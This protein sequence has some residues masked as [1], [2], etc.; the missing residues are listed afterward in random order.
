[1]LPEI[2]HPAGKTGGDLC[3]GWLAL[4][5]GMDFA[6][7]T[8]ISA[9]ALGVRSIADGFAL[10][11][12][13]GNARLIYAEDQVNRVLSYSLGSV[14]APGSGY[15]S[16]PGLAAP[17]EI[18][19]LDPGASLAFHIRGSQ[20]RSYA[21]DS[22]IGTMTSAVL[23]PTGTPGA[24]TWVPTP[25]VGIKGVQTFTVIGGATGGHAAIS[26]YGAAGLKLF[27]V[28]ANGSLNLT[29]QISDSDK[30]HI[31]N[32]SATA[33]LTLGGQAYLLTLSSLENGITSFA[34]DGAGKAELVDSLG[35]RDQLPISGPEA[36]RIVNLAGQSFAVIASTG[37]SSLTVVR[38]ND[39]GCL[40]QT[41]HVIDDAST[42]FH[43]ASV[44]DTFTLNGRSFL[45]TAGADAGI[46]VMELLPGG[47]LA[48][49]AT[50]VF[51]TGAGFFAAKGLDVV[52]NGTT[53]WIF[54]L[55][56]RS[57]RLQRFDLDLSDL[58][59]RYT[60]QNGLAIGSSKDDLIMGSAGNDSLS[61]GGGDDRIVSGGGADT[62]TGG[63]GAD[64]FVFGAASDDLVITDFVLHQDRIDLSDWGRVYSV[65]ALSITPT[66]DG[67][68]IAL[69]GHEVTLV[70]GQSL[71][72]ANFTAADFLF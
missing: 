43:R 36:M 4:G 45:A 58:G 70:A 54:A 9:A 1:M 72:A 14:S 47:Q 55:D 23:D 50:G 27:Q 69:N 24:S 22:T 26:T 53:A 33:S 28:N 71:S 59:W 42:R 2:V 18:W 63:L 5:V 56:S 19:N 34:V 64:T 60:A 35:T 16:P 7:G 68:R 29:D 10:I 8:T 37:S 20:I 48:H 44:L 6:L 17:P 57:D 51:E 3:A 11:V 15:L 62:M 21:F 13:G 39:L 65:A 46:T 30:A 25:S 32:I 61:G 41:D 49:L 66:A 67:C 12:A 40:F 31:G 52:V 38:I